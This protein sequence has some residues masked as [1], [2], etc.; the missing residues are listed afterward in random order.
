MSTTTSPT[1]TY[2]CSVCGAVSSHPADDDFAVCNT[3]DAC[4]LLFDDERVLVLA[5]AAPAPV[6]PALPVR[7]PAPVARY[8]KFRLTYIPEGGYIEGDERTYDVIYRGCTIGTVGRCYLPS[9]VE[10]GLPLDGWAFAD[11]G[12]RVGDGLTRAAAVLSAWS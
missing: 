2:R 9:P 10:G 11:Y 8:L 4:G 5:P 7:Q 1:T 3:T 6:V 12:G